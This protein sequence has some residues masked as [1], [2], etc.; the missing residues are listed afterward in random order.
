MPIPLRAILGIPYNGK[1]V[2]YTC[3]EI[4]KGMASP[5]L[6]VSLITPRLNKPLGGDVQVIQALPRWARWPVP[7]RLVEAYSQSRVGSAVGR[8]LSRRGIE[9]GGVAYLWG[10]ECISATRELRRHGILTIWE[11]T[12]CHR[13]TVKRILDDAYSRAGLAPAHGVSDESVMH[14][15]EFLAELDFVF[16]PSTLVWDSLR[17]HNV[18]ED[19][20]LRASYGWSPER[21]TATRKR[22]RPGKGVTFAFVGSISIRKGAHLLLEYWV[23]S[24][25]RGRLILA[26]VMEPAVARLCGDLLNR[27]DI[28][29]T[30]YVEDVAAV[31]QSADVFVF[32]TLEE[33]APLVT[34]EAAGCG[35]PVVTG[36]MGGAGIIQNEVNGYILD[37]Y[38]AEAWVE[39]L[40]KLA[41]SEELCCRLGE[42]AQESAHR[43]TWEQVGERRRNLILKLLKHR[44][45][46]I[47]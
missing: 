5:E 38:D 12:N 19:K 29:V 37:P 22:S 31:Y 15:D 47:G 40:R 1:A 33:G 2:S 8:A 41:G 13:G 16:C 21:F 18:P 28:T 3:G 45:N 39:T 17:E 44:V 20:L 35:L 27:E 11:K 7:Y 9:R 42:A 23:R 10:F 46:L 26:G 30:G 25:V 36:P 32:P 6:D 34:Y 24:G 14:E 4:L 43:F